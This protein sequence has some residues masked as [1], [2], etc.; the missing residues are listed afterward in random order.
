MPWQQQVVDVG[1]ELDPQ[2]GRLAYREL[3]VTVMRQSGKSV[4]VLTVEVDRCVSWESPQ[5]VAYTAQTGWDA[6]R[7]LVDD[8]AP[9]L[10]SSKLSGL[11]DR[12]LRGAGNEGVVF[13]SG[14][15]IDV[16]ASTA[17]AGHGRTLDL[18]V[19][20][21]AFDD[22]DD[23]REQSILPAMATRPDAQL[24]VVSTAGTE[25]STYLRRK[26]ES[27][28]A[29]AGADRGKGIAYFEWSIPD[30]ADVDDP[31]VWWQYMPALGW[32]ITED[33]VAHAR[34]SMSDAEFRRGF[35][36]QW[37]RA[38]VE[39]IIPL[40]VWAQV[41]DVD[42]AP[43]QPLVWAFDVMPDRSSSAVAAAGDGQV[44]VVDHRPG[45]SWLVER[46]VD[47]VGR[48]GG[49][50]AFDAGGPAGSLA[51]DL[52]Q[53]GLKLLP[54]SNPQVI[55]SCARLY[56]WVAD[57]K[58][59]VRPHPALD[60]AVAGLAKKPVGDRFVWSRANSTADITPLY[61]VTFALGATSEEKRP[62][63]FF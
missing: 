13:K 27:G 24:L 33:A 25:A 14:A 2:T 55:A 26:V 54:A 20:D 38:D 34:R 3:V 1:L 48:H 17:S 29:E 51:A 30:D 39:R 43:G 12:V 9:V 18:G 32:T 36:N 60:S 52:E 22:E 53:A 16:M 37:V 57:G 61:A 28:R 40:E 46:L 58:V 21:E 6:R 7:K 11:V 8:H 41:Q 47:L 59:R 31:A 42:A 49:Q 45:V 4:L 44:E 56:D 62:F 23:R 63:A 19:I 50:V 5:R 10:T 15:R 35:G